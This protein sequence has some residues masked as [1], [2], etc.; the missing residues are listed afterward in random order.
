MIRLKKSE[1]G[2]EE[3]RR[4]PSDAIGAAGIGLLTLVYLAEARRL[5]FGGPSAPD[6]GFLPLSLG[7]GLLV[8]CLILFLRALLRRG[9]EA[10]PTAPIMRPTIKRISLLVA[11]LA[12][13]PL[14]LQAGGF[15]PATGVSLFVIFRAIKY[16]GW[17]ASGL[18]T[19]ATTLLAYLIFAVWLHVY[20]PKGVWG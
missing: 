2:D 9:A 11:S 6:L 14:L 15:M 12:A 5:P 3:M 4:L 20:F 1:T 10:R 16:R 18:L 13:Y 8:L 7:C 19:L 17:L